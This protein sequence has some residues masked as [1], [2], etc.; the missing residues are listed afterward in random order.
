MPFGRTTR[1]MIATALVLTAAPQSGLTAATST[2]TAASISARDKSEGAKAHP[3]LVAE[4]G[5]A[6]TGPQADYV[7]S[8]GKKVALQSGL[9][10]ASSDFTV[11]LLDSSINNAFAIPGGYIYT[12]RQLV[13]LMNN[14]A[15]LGGVLGHE[16]AHVALRHSAKRQ[17]NSTKNQIVGVLGALLS[18]VVLGSSQVGQL[19]QKGFLQGSQLLTLSFSRKQESEADTFGIKYLRAA[20]YDPRAMSTVLQSLA[21]QNALDSKLLGT[22][23]QVPAWASTHPDPASRVRTTAAQA[24]TSSTGVSNRDVFLSKIGG[25]IYGDS[26]A[27]G[28]A[29]GR[30]FKHPIEKLAFDAPAGFYLVNGTQAVA[31]SGQSGKG[32]FTTAAFDGNLDSYVAAQFAKL[33]QANRAQL[34]PSAIQRTT[35]NGIPAAYASA[36]VNSGTSQVDVTVFAYQWNNTQAYHFLTITQAGQNPFDSM[37]G[38]MRRLTDAQAATLKPR[39]LQVISVKS[40]DTMQSLSAR[41]AYTDA[42]LQRFQVLNGLTTNSRLSAGQKV[43]LVTY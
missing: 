19:L 27:Q 6:I 20:G 10:N 35:I 32:Q 4:Y 34:T 2:T 30:S 13:G 24:G 16:T 11:T 26:P 41:M 43:K 3:Q 29:E 7:A 12:T 18:G 40:G 21:N 36:R 14:E 17:S 37:F 15:E 5:G 31:I 25:L 23:D 39:R 33:A 38:T 42:P 9:S 8:I 22:S 1:Y 28:Y